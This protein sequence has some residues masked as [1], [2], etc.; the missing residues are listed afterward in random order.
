MFAGGFT[1]EAAEAVCGLDAL[2][3][4]AA[5]V[6]HSLLTSRDRAL[7]DARDGPRVR[8]RPARGTGTLD[9]AR[10]AHARYFA[11]RGRGRRARHGERRRS[12][13]WLDRLDAERENVRA[14]IAFAVADGDAAPRSR[15]A[16]TLWRYWSG[17]G[18]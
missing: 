6:E 13:T 16:P 7:R 1:L 9:E 2:D 15:C 10:R 18:T 5:L 12:A 8:A 14:A 3:G 11:E 17:A 4:I